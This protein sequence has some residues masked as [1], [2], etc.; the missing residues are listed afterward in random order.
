MRGAGGAPARAGLAA[1]ALLAALYAATAAPAVTFWDAGE[2]VAAFASYGVPHPPGTPLFVALGR[3][4]TLT[5]GALGI[6]GA[7]AAALLSATCTAAAGGVTAALVTRWTGSTRAGVAAAL[8][9][10]TMSTV[11]ASAT[12]PEVYAPALLLA[13]LALLAA[14]A[15]GRARAAR[16]D[17]APAASGSRATLAAAYALGLAAPLHPSALVCA[18]VVAWLAA[19]P[20]GDVDRRS[21]RWHRGFMIVAGAGLTAGLGG[22]S[23]AVV[24]L[25]LV[26][27]GAL[28]IRGGPKSDGRLALGIAA[29]TLVAASALLALWVRARHDPWLNQAAPVT[30]PAFRDVLTRAQYAPAGLWPRQAPLWLQLANVGEWADWQVGLGLDGGVGPRPLR[31]PWTIAYAV[32][33]A[34]GAAWHRRRDPRSF[35]AWALLLACGTAGVAVYLNLKAGPSFGAGV[36]P[37]DAPHE[38]RERDYFFALGWW[39]WGAWAGVGAVVLARR[40]ARR[41]SGGRARRAVALGGGLAA[42]ALPGAL[43]WRAVDRRREP[44]AST[45]DAYARALLAAAPPRA[46]LLVR[47][48]NDTYPLWAAQSG[49]FRRDVTTVTLSLLPARWY[50][51]ELARRHGLV[52]AAM[53]RAWPGEA[54][55]VRALAAAAAAAGRPMATTLSVE[56]ATRADA[57]GRW[58]HAGLLIERRDGD[59]NA[60]GGAVAPAVGALIGDVEADS[61]A[62]LASARLVGALAPRLFLARPGPAEAGV[63]VWARRQLA[64]PAALLAAWGQPEP[65][66]RAA[67][68]RR[69]EGA[70][71]GR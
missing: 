42:A 37:P 71:Q 44:A 3:A 43:N 1:G 38:A 49:G 52:P 54:L 8:T 60:G 9:A 64:C 68:A 7:A 35:G 39:A 24:A 31:L 41:V 36:L 28:A 65:V 23:G 2:F 22:G 30:W 14:D 11:W 51:A 47:A 40:L 20:A 45:A 16:A 17:D 56:P 34:F 59:A 48:D 29:L 18:P 57:G 32:L 15:A 61:A 63:G 69:V 33:A 46:V 62:V 26:L 21:V 67:G 53:E 6:G 13:T 58:V 4:W 5:L 50:R 55:L 27:L 66:P 70:C 10:G 19:V 12:E 25:A